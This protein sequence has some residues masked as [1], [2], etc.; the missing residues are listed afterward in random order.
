[1]AVVCTVQQFRAYVENYLRQ[2]EADDE[3][4]MV[5]VGG[6]E[7]DISVRAPNDSNGSKR[8]GSIG[9]PKE[10]FSKQE[11]TY[12]L[13]KIVSGYVDRDRFVG[14]MA[15]T[16]SEVS[17]DAI[18]KYVDTQEASYGEMLEGTDV[19]RDTIVEALAD[20]TAL[21]EDVLE[22][23]ADHALIAARQRENARATT[24]KADGGEHE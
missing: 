7:G 1:M 14:T 17:E 21:P 2:L 9:F 12:P 13:S 24:L 18:E 20:A 4:W 3:D 22:P 8:I 19:E 15:V 23:I 10:L 6:L 5:V 16:R 11:G